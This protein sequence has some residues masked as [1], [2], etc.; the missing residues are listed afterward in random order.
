[1]HPQLKEILKPAYQ[2]VGFDSTCDPPMRWT[3]HSG[4]VPRGFYG[5]TGELEEVT[6]VLV[7]A[8]PGNPSPNPGPEECYED[9]ESAFGFT[10]YCFL[11]GGGQG[12]ENVRHLICRCFPG[13]S[14]VDAM[15]KVWI[16]ESVLCSRSRYR[17]LLCREVSP[18]SVTLVPACHD[19]GHGVQ[20]HDS[21]QA[22]PSPDPQPNR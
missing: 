1:M 7:L 9:V 2:C 16:T 12:H 20:G 4:H 11:T 21:A 10:G 6:L 3:P 17:A 18:E 13:L 5:A 19:S 14:L 15:R 22:L 8:E